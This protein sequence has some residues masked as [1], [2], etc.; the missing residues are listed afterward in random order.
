MDTVTTAADESKANSNL[1]YAYHSTRLTSRT[2]N[3]PSGN[4]RLSYKAPFGLQVSG[5]VGHTV[6]VPDARERYFALK[7]MGSELGRKSGTK[8]QP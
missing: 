6:R 3:F 1:Y 5:G 7:R 8:P 4:A 2:N